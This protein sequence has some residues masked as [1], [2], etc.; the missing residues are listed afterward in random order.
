MQTELLAAYREDLELRNL[1]TT[2][3]HV[4]TVRAWIQWCTR[5]GIDP[6]AVS[7]EDFKAYLA[8]RRQAGYGLRLSRF[9]WHPHVCSCHPSGGN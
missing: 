4:G 5:E 1:A 8:D 2:K 9:M 7:R 3:G 6:L